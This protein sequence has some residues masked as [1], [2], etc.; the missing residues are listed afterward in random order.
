MDDKNRCT[1]HDTAQPACPLYATHPLLDARGRPWANLCD[2]H[3][4]QFEAM[5]RHPN[6]RRAL[7]AWVHASGGPE[8]LAEPGTPVGVMETF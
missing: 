7:A 6:F 4:D 5:V 2:T 3:N 8:K 1:W